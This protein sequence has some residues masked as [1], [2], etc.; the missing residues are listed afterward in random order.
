MKKVLVMGGTEFVGR[1][2][3][4]GLISKGYQVDFLTRGIK[5]V[6][7]LGYKKHYICDRKN[8]SEL[9]RY[10][11]GNMYDYIFDISAYSR[12]DVE[13][14]LKSVNLSTIK[15]YCFLSSGAVY[16]PNS[17]Y[18]YENNE[19]GSNP[20]WGQYGLDKN[21]AE[22]YL[23]NLSKNNGFPMVI[24]RPSYIYGEGNNLYRESYFFHRILNNK[25]IPVPNTG[26]KTQFIH[27]KDV[28][29]IMLNSITNDKT[30][31]EA[32]NLTHPREFEWKEFVETIQKIIS[33]HTTIL[34]VSQED[35]DKLNVIPRQFFPFRDITYL[36]NINKLKEHN[37]P[38]PRI[39]IEKGLQ[40]SFD[41][42]L[43][44][45]MIEEFDCMKELERVTNY[46]LLKNV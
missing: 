26:K 39:D 45:N 13:I 28:V 42:F 41:W 33:K 10:L 24:F 18:L 11:S 9:K 23:F 31:G 46:C 14:L 34:G 20:N 32:Y 22:D 15:R 40:A 19:R 27:I 8:E 25:L 7:T 38:L 12:K 17:N 44:Q 36:M 4:N 35:M 6:S 16:T 2:I 37:L 43:Q 29:D 21:E 30:V 3:L 5:E 1:A